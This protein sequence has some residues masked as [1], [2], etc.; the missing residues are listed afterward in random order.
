M[1]YILKSKSLLTTL[2][3]GGMMLVAGCN[4]ANQPQPTVDPDPVESPLKAQVRALPLPNGMD[5]GSEPGVLPPLD[6]IEPEVDG[7][8]VTPGTFGGLKGVYINQKKVYKSGFAFD[9]L[10]IFNPAG[11]LI[12][13]GSV[14]KGNSITNGDYVRLPGTVGE[15]TLSAN[16]LIPSSPMNAPFVENLSNPKESDYNMTMQRWFSSQTQPLSATTMFEVNELS[17]SK[18]VGVELGVGYK[19]EDL[20]A[21]LKLSTTHQRMNTHVLVKAVQKVFSVAVDVPDGFILKSAKVEDM[22]GVM[23]VYVSEVF[24]GRMGFAVISSNHEFHEV[25]AALNLNV[26]T[27][28]ENINFDIQ[29]KYKQILDSSIS[30]TRIIG[31]TSEEHGYGLSM[32]WE[33]FKK[34]L[35]APLAPFSAVPIAYTLRYVHDN[36]VARVVLTSNF[37]RNESYFVPEMDELKIRF[38]PR[39]VR[40]M[41]DNYKPIYLYGKVTISLDG[42][43]QTIFDRPVNRYIRIDNPSEDVLLDDMETI[44]VTLRRPSGMSM[45]DFLKKEV[46]VSGSFGHANPNG[47]N[48]LFGLGSDSQAYTVRELLMSAMRG[49]MSFDTQ[50]KRVNK[51]EANLVLDVQIEDGIRVVNGTIPVM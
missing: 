33:G 32:G 51:R 24:Y 42:E 5:S 38:T 37:T 34:T 30:K 27:D 49:A 44:E 12:F 35:S 20:I 36:S 23:P 14:F 31:G 48:S 7:E 43:T 10:S 19:R 47:T 40:A 21:S 15:V 26:P 22:G 2:L 39:S 17:N 45:V 16:S 29:T 50:E 46:I 9:E 28:K 1:K 4:K 25:V 41:A 18:E 11:N 8:T 6:P 13:P 3:V